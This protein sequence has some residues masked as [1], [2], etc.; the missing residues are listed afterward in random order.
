MIMDKLKK[1]AENP[2]L[3]PGIYNYCDRWCERC[4][5]TSRC[6][7]FAMEKEFPSNR[8]FLDLS[9]A[10]FW[11]T[12]ASILD[13]TLELLHEMAREKGVDFDL[14]INEE[15]RVEL[16]E[17]HRRSRRHICSILA[18][19]YADMVDDWVSTSGQFSEVAFRLPGTASPGEIPDL[20][21]ARE[22]ILWYQH[23]IPVKIMRALQSR[24]DAQ[25]SLPEH[26]IRDWDGSAKVALLGIDRSMAAW[27]VMQAYMIDFR[28]DIEEKLFCLE[29]LRRKIEAVFPGARSFVRP[30]FDEI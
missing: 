4:T 15:D 8:D 28:E 23:L 26:C 7:S 3:I 12:M 14:D 24:T 17:T 6:M 13:S 30:G 20:Q 2:M 19:K 10:S 21:D 5:F 29:R 27:G 22:V 18:Y 11:E 9:N 25:E 1:M 16:E